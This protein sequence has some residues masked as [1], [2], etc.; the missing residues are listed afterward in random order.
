MPIRCVGLLICFRKLK[1]RTF[2][3]ILR[4]AEN[5]FLIKKI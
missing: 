1:N 5:V 3:D 4:K 2:Y